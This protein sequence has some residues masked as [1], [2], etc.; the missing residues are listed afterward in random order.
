MEKG[1]LR[2][3]ARGRRGEKFA[4]RHQRQTSRKHFAQFFQISEMNFLATV[5]SLGSGGKS[6]TVWLL[7]AISQALCNGVGWVICWQVGESRRQAG[8]SP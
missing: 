4:A 7:R 5:E 8:S 6:S 1:L 2:K 3:G